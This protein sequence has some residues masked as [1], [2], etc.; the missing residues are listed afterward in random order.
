MVTFLEKTTSGRRYLHIQPSENDVDGEGTKLPVRNPTT[1]LCKPDCV[2]GPPSLPWWSKENLK[3]GETFLLSTHVKMKKNLPSYQLLRHDIEFERRS[4]A[5]LPL[6]GEFSYKPLYWEWCLETNTLHTSKG[7]VSL[8]IFDIY[9]FLGLPISGHLYDEVVPTQ[10]ELV[11]KLSLSCTY[12]FIAYHK[13]MQGRKGK[14]TIEQ[15]ISFWFRGRSKYHVSKKPDQGSRIPQ[16]GILSPLPDAGARGWSD[17]QAIFDELGV[18]TGQRTE[19]FLAAF[20]SC[21]LCTFILPVRD[22]GCIRPGTFSIASLMASGVGYCLPTAVLASIYKGINELSRSSHPGRGGGHFPTHFLYAW[23]AKN[24]DAYELVGEASSSPG[25][26]KFSGLGQ[27][28]SFQPEEAPM[29]QYH[30]MLRRYGT[31]SQVLLPGRCNLLEKN[32]TRAFREWWPKMFV[33]PPCSPHANGSKRKRSDLSDTNISKDEGK[34]KPKLKIIR[35]GRPVEP[36]VPVIENGSSRVEISG[37]DVG[38]LAMPIPAIPI[39]SIAPLPQDELPI[40]VCEPSTQKVT[41]LPPEGAENIMDILDAEPNPIECMGESDDVNFK[42]GLAHIPLPSGS[43]CFLS[44]GCIP[45]FGKDLFDSRSRLVSSRGVCP[46]DDDEVESIRKVN[47]HSPVP[48]P[49]R[50]LK[51]P[52]GGISV[53]DADAFIKEVDKNATRVLGKAIVDKVCRTPFDRL[54][55]L[56]GDF[57]SLYATILQK[58]VD[59]TPLESRVEGLIRQACDFKDLQQSY[60]GRISAEEH[61]N[62]RMEVQGKLDEASRQVN[63]EGTHYEAKAAELKHVESR[64][65]ELLKELQLLEDQQKELSSQVAASEHLLQEAEREVIDLQGQIEVLNATEVMDAATKASLEKAEAYIKESFEDLKNFQWD[66]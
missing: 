55:S 10:R 41:E 13:L 14:P 12:L 46:P 2:R 31:G 23:L 37:I 5:K 30:H 66:P 65:Q 20:L 26:V 3:T 34:L 27:A 7:E 36:F 35:S 61:N 59:V 60:S 48:R 49:Q 50:P 40:E 18:A 28:K 6:H 17:Y 56:R 64:R 29:L 21:W 32:T 51:V 15:W 11:S 54:P 19:T 47:A 22:A 42:E 4:W 43:Q 33:F 24:F 52:Q 53:F 16:P 38:T 9:S 44:V 25:M 45:S 57:D 58:G 63:T 39:R 62:C 1:S 8:S